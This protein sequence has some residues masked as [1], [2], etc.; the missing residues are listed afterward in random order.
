MT[1]RHHLLCVLAGVL[2]V[3]AQVAVDDLPDVLSEEISRFQQLVSSAVLERR[4]EGIQ[5]ASH[6]RLQSFEPELLPILE[7]R[8]PELRREAVQA[9]VHC[10]TVR[11]VP[12]LIARVADTDWATREHARIALQLMTAQVDLPGQIQA[13]QTW[14][15]LST[16][17]AKQQRL[18]SLL[19]VPDVLQRI[20][21]ARALRCLAT[22]DME[23]DIL[24]ALK[25]G[26]PIGGKER[27]HLTEALDRIGAAASMPYFLE[28]AAVGDAA[29]AWALG[30]RG[31]AEA[32]EALLKGVRRNRGLDLLLNL[33]RLKTRKCAPFLPALCRNFI[34]VIRAGYAEDIRYRPAP[35]RRVSANLI[36]RSGKGS[37]LVELILSEMEGKPKGDQI[38][39][40]LKPLFVD[41][42]KVLKPEFVREGFSGCDALLGVLPDVAD[43]PALTPRLLPLLRSDILLVRVYAGL[44]L[45]RLQAQEAVEPIVSIV[46]DGYPFS[47]STAAA[48]GKHT[49]SFVQ[50]DG[51]RQR[52]S[53]TVRWLGYLCVALGDIG[54][55]R[56]RRALESFALD[57]A[58]PRDVRYGSV[59]A[60]SRLGSPAALPALRR[61]AR[62][63]IIWLIRDTAERA[64]ADIELGGRSE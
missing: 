62:D 53:Q 49:S 55:D 59:V 17:G 19:S 43:D 27:K 30:R 51:K 42:R 45:G 6:L 63:D 34:T 10:G 41:L 16:L 11:S 21:A 3:C 26:A 25:G 44:T 54:G 14:W 47:D 36:R 8:E 38:P 64:I 12:A 13:W 40:N 15:D 60:L 48:S 9:L 57:S 50:V 28:R 35:M 39:Q 4:I 23:E 46:R 31:G 5:G 2:P 29:A 56:S 7:S 32:E 37:M 61:V 1:L 24:A 52:Q 22:E 20:S 18:L 33:D 58:S